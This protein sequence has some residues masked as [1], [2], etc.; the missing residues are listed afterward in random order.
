MLKRR[1]IEPLA[2]EY[3]TLAIHEGKLEKMFLDSIVAVRVC[4]YVYHTRQDTG[5]GLEGSRG[6]EVVVCIEP[7]WCFFD[8]WFF[9]SPQ[10]HLRLGF[11]QNLPCHLYSPQLATEASLSLPVCVG[12]ALHEQSQG[13][14]LSTYSGRVVNARG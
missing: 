3:D 9:N 7:H 6:L 1:N 8:P 10:K 13:G 2:D 12:I 11:S 5:V 14:C 4:V